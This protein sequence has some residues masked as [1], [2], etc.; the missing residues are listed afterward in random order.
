MRFS[1]T[2]PLALSTVFAGFSLAKA[3]DQGPLEIRNLRSLSVPFLRIDPRPAILAKGDRTLSVGFT[4]AN[5]IRKQYAGGVLAVDEDYEIDRLLFRYR[6]GIGNGMDV[7]IDAPVI[8]RSGGF[9]DSLVSGWHALVL[10]GY[11]SARDGVPYGECHVIVPGSGPYGSAFGIGDISVWLSKNL[12]PRWMATA[13]LK[14][15][16]GQASQLL[17]SG[18]VDAALA[19][20]YHTQLSSR[21]SAYAQAGV[22]AQGKTTELKGTRGL[23]PQEALAVVWHPNS[24]DSWVA[25]WQGEDSAT[26]TGVAGSD[27][28]HRQISF[29]FHRVLS[30]NQSLELFFS[31]DKDFLNYPRGLTGTAPDFTAGVRWTKKF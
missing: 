7:T 25:Q 21:W 6:T 31:E 11:A 20:Q 18:A 8:D 4:S 9:M 22:V 5:D 2:V 19:F 13:A 3:D 29:G 23:V 26:V 27:A 1:L 30:A 24:R 17:G 16:T 12:G 14:A 28:P 10:G 15:P